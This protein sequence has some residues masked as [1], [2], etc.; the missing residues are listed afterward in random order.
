MGFVATDDVD[1]HQMLFLLHFLS[2]PLKG[3]NVLFVQKYMLFIVLILFQNF[4]MHHM[5]AVVVQS[6]TPYLHTSQTNFDC[7][8]TRKR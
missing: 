4:I 6:V 7:N 3:V 8:V 1:C 5:L 2:F